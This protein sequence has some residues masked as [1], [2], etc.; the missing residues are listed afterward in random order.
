MA[1]SDKSALSAAIENLNAG[2]IL[3]YPTETF[4]GLGARHDDGNAIRRIY[5][6]KRRPADKALPVIIGNRAHLSLLTD[7]KD[8]RADMLM[9]RF[10][11][12]PLTLIMTALPG[13]TEGI[14]HEKK[15]A[16][17]IPGP[18]FALTLACA[19][20]YPITS[21]SANVSGLPPA[22]SARMVISY[23]GDAVYLVIDG[24]ESPS[25]LPSTIVDLTAADPVIVR[26]GIIPAATILALI[27]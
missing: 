8:P 12:G 4:Y 24:G 19:A 20:G 3:A 1:A 2:R 14:V 11:P 9:E 16:V 26:E 17:R 21:T 27:R 7:M 10:W 23:F 18:S 5:A 6:A 25:S 15:I 13:L 22:A